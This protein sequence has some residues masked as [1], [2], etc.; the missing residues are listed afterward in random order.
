MA[1]PV[2]ECSIYRVSIHKNGGYMY[3]STHPFTI[4]PDGKRKYSN[5]HWGTVDEGLKFHPGKQFLYASLEERSRLIFPEGWDL[6][7]TEKLSG[8]RS[9]G[10]ASYNEEDANRFYG[11]VWLLDQVA[12]KTGLRKDL[13]A[14]FHENAEMVDDIL[15]L[16]YFPYLTGFTY[17]RLARWQRIV[18]TPSSRELTPTVITRLTQSISERERMNLFRLR[19]GRLDKDELCAVDSTSRSAYG[20]G[21]SD[22]RWGHNKEGLS[23]EQTLEVVV[24][25]LQSH[26]PV[27]Y[28]TFPGNIPDSRS[29]ETIL[30]NLS[31][32][33]FPKVILV[34]DRGYDSL[35]NMERYILRRQPMIL[36]A[37]VR[38]S[39]VMEKILELG[40]FS[41]RPEG[42]QVDGE[43]RIYHK[44]YALE[45]T[46]VGE[47]GATIKADRLRLNLYFD[48]VRRGQELTSL[49]IQVES[50]RRALQA[51]LDA[52]ESLDDEASVRKNYNWFD[53][54]CRDTDRLLLSF[55]PNQKKISLAKRASGFF[56]NITLGLDMGAMEALDAYSLRD[57]QEK[58][59]QQMKGQ[60]G[61][62]KQ[63]NW[64]EEGK[65]G[66]LLILFTALIISS[67]VRHIWKSTDLKKKF[68][69]ALEI[70]DEMRSIR[71]IE[72]KGRG[73]FITP[74]V[75]LQVE[76]CKA[77][78]FEIPNG[79]APKYTSKKKSEKKRGRPKKQQV[80]KLDS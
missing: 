57:E 34:T 49:D 43:R 17:N 32:A 39:L 9:Q 79:C 26:M 18:K 52:S 63:R 5:L 65:T 73:R 67:Y 44:Q 74:F 61:F 78:G 80:V 56:A 23:L 13:L 40:E 77:F 58:Y 53:V 24:Y 66:R 76:I 38:Q 25:S 50:Q 69:S 10:R 27:Y 59:F 14:V 42:M 48:A 11:D 71:C 60:M 19:A 2:S 6:S 30:T 70:L 16:A 54:E 20:D 33:G 55:T 51:I 64:S 45:Y 12:R 8:K 22:I 37:K 68:S 4:S 31:H 21:L 1:R 29:M 3:A 15:T 75:G 47:R 35:A 72:H 46:L 28:R 62:D 41:G 7:E 36:C